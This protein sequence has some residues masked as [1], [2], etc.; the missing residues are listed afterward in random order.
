[1]AQPA[2]SRPV[3][4]DFRYR[5]AIEIRFGD[6]DAL[7]HV[8]NAVY[9]AYFEMARGGYYTAVVGHPF[10]HGPEADRRTYVIAEAHVTYRTPA[11]YGEALTCACR[12]GWLGRSSFSLEY[13]L[14]VGASEHRSGA[15]HRRWLHGPGLLRLRGRQGHAHPGGDGAPTGRLRGPRAAVT[16]RRRLRLGRYLRRRWP[17]ARRV[18]PPW[19]RPAAAPSAPGS[20]APRGPPPGRTA[21]ACRRPSG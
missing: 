14:E 3:D 18:G 17:G 11:L 5:H 20:P 19:P 8:N 7:G 4:G 2:R 15:P 6:T 13:R 9:L 10:G 1:M 21:R 16:P 12:V